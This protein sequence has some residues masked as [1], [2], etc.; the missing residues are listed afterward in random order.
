MLPHIG[1]NDEPQMP[2]LWRREHWAEL[3]YE[4]INSYRVGSF[5]ACVIL[6]H[7]CTRRLLSEAVR[8]VPRQWAAGISGVVQRGWWG[9]CAYWVEWASSPDGPQFTLSFPPHRQLALNSG[10]S[11]QVHAL[12][13]RYAGIGFA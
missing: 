7:S 8:Y 10:G 9:K 11:G 2:G 1:A 13:E 12:L 5:A 4:E 3:P 6:V